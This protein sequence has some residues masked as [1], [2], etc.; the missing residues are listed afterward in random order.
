MSS[1]GSPKAAAPEAIEYM[2]ELTGMANRALPKDPDPMG[3][4]T[5][6]YT[7]GNLRRQLRKIRPNLAQG[8][9][10]PHLYPLSQMTDAPLRYFLDDLRAAVEE[11]QRHD[12]FETWRL[13][14]I[15]KPGRDR[16]DLPSGCRP[17]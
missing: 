6:E 7:L 4:L 17:I 5:M 3:W 1:G 11:N 9:K 13:V 14:F 2:L 12:S 8:Y 15:H 16:Y 10:G